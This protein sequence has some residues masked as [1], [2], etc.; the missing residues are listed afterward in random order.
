MNGR[1]VLWVALAILA[2]FWMSG[3]AAAYWT[4]GSSYVPA[5]GYLGSYWPSVY[6]REYVPYFAQHP[7]VYYSY[8]VGRTYGR[9]PYAWPPIVRT[10]PQRPVAE[11]S[12][13]IIPNPYAVSSEPAAAPVE[14]SRTAPMRIVNSYVQ[15]SLE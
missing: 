5:P 14:V 11:P 13:L 7:P 1:W 3:D 15:H 2:A 4:C 12:P 9:S 10:A 6:S 8:P